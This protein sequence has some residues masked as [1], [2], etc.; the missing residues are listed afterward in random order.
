MLK[1]EE[2]LQKMEELK[3]RFADIQAQR[4]EHLDKINEIDLES[5]KLDGA[6]TAYQ[7]LIKKID[8]EK[9]TE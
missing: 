4:K 8:E 1:K 7:D 3:V 2:I 6:F 9:T 5:L